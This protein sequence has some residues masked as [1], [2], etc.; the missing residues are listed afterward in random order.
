MPGIYPAVGP[1]M[2]LYR[3]CWVEEGEIKSSHAQFVRMA[4]KHMESLL[5]KGQPSWM[6]P[7]PPGDVE[8]DDIPF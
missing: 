8:L 5:V 4:L 2:S 7:V 3:V 6:V 1:E